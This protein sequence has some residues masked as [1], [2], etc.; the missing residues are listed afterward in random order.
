MTDYFNR[1]LVEAL[2]APD[3]DEDEFSHTL[4][5]IAAANN[6]S[7]LVAEK[8]T[9][10]DLD[11]ASVSEAYLAEIATDIMERLNSGEL[12]LDGTQNTVFSISAGKNDD[13][14]RFW[15]IFKEHS[16]R[17]S[18]YRTTIYKRKR[19]PV[20]QGCSTDMGGKW[21]TT[22]A[23]VMPLPRG[24]MEA[25]EA[26]DN[27]DDSFG[28]DTRFKYYKELKE[29]VD[30]LN[31]SDINPTLILEMEPESGRYCDFLTDLWETVFEQFV[32]IT[33][34]HPDD[35][36]RFD[37]AWCGDLERKDEIRYIDG[38]WRW[39]NSPEE[40][41]DDIIGEA[42]EAPHNDDDEFGDSIN[43]FSLNLEG[44]KDFLN[45]TKVTPGDLV[46]RKSAIIGLNWRLGNYH[47]TEDCRVIYVVSD[48]CPDVYADI[49]WEERRWKVNGWTVGTPPPE[50]AAN[51]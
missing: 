24:M 21:S 12:E 19:H 46:F 4:N 8:C 49:Y 39:V 1:S 50:I 27:D 2:E 36:D 34:R 15:L 11:I 35:Y 20:V 40:F 13:W 48:N 45:R 9:E 51:L 17:P 7:Y 22:T 47:V 29:F 26:P 44:L 3:N 33:R 18:T 30:Q 31:D 23:L 41:S 10:M 25:L 16:E 38:V 37:I 32:E 28:D 42:L 6:I 5:P 14:L 43:E